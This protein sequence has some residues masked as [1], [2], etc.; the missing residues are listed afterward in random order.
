ML[1]KLS[2]EDFVALRGPF[3]SGRQSPNSL[4][5]TLILFIFFQPLMFF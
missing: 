2:E 1:Q 4:S 5:L 3:E